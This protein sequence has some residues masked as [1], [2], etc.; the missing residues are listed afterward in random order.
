MARSKEA[1]TKKL[2]KDL[3]VSEEKIKKVKGGF[4]PQPEPPGRKPPPPR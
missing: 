4:N 1:K 2:I 3:K